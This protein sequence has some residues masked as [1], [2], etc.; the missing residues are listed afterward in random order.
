MSARAASSRAL[1]D[2]EEAISARSASSSDDAGFPLICVLYSRA[3]AKAERG[4][5]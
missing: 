1:A 3:D 2:S 5:E 4:V